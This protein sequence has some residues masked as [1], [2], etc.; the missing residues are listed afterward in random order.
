M[1]K[2]RT[3]FH[4]LQRDNFFCVIN[5]YAM[6]DFRDKRAVLKFSLLLGTKGIEILEMLKMA[7]KDDAMRK[8]QVLHWFSRFEN[9]EK[10]NDN[11]SHSVVL[12]RLS[13]HQRLMTDH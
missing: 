12:P 6:A 4:R 7:Y 13:N 9:G 11:K 2:V 1:R 10:S 5:I 3:S 8:T